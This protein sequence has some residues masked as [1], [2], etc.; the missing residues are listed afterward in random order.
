MNVKT[1]HIAGVQN[2]VIRYT[3][4]MDNPSGAIIIN[5]VVKVPE[6][7]RSKMSEAIGAN[8]FFE[9]VRPEIDT[10]RLSMRFGREGRVMWSQHDGFIK[11]NLVLVEDKYD[12]EYMDK[13][14]DLPHI[15]KNELLIVNME[16][17]SAKQITYIST[18]E[19]MLISKGIVT[20]EEVVSL[21]ETV[22]KEYVKEYRRFT[23]VDDAENY[24]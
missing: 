10:R 1:I 3:E 24:K 2:D 8:R 7:D 16:K 4:E 19:S 20:E 5:C 11:R 13:G 21:K 23:I 9:V 15:S 12:L 6:L 22:E 14:D 18:L 17:E